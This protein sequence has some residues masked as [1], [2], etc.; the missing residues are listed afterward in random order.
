MDPAFPYQG[1]RLRLNKQPTDDA[2]PELV[3]FHLKAVNQFAKEFDHFSQCI[4]ENQP[5]KTPG[6]MGLADLRVVL[7]VQESIRSGRPIPVGETSPV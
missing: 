5:V 4:R 3:E 1:Q 6:A 7:A 2:N